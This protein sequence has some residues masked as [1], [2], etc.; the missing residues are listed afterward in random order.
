MKTEKISTLGNGMKVVTLPMPEKQKAA[1]FVGVRVGSINENDKNNGV[2]HF[3]EHMLFRSNK[4]RNSDQIKRDLEWKG[5]STNAFTSN[6]STAFFVKSPPHT[7]KDAV[8]IGFEAYTNLD[9]V[10]KE[11]D[12]EREVIL[13]EIKRSRENHDQH[14]LSNLLSP[15]FFKGTDLERT[16]LGPEEVISNISRDAMAGFKKKF[17]VPQNTVISVVGNFDENQVLDQLGQTFG[18]LPAQEFDQEPANTEVDVKPKEPYY[19]ERE[20]IKQLYMAQA[21]KV[22]DEFAT[23]EYYAMRLL[24][25]AIGSGLSSRMFRELR[26]KRGV[27]YVTFSMYWGYPQGIIVFY[28]GGMKPEQLDEVRETLEEITS[29]IAVNSLPEEEAEG[30]RNKYVSQLQDSLEFVEWI[31]MSLFQKTMF[32]LPISILDAIDGANSVSGDS[33]RKVAD[34]HLTKPRIEVGLRPA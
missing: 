16:V 14:V 23:D 7:L 29:D 9:Y 15:Y 5:I 25:N 21:V 34:I 17:Y 8:Q 3:T 20:N 32:D 31:A 18:K 27:G 13:G 26:D 6:N 12:T 22:P 4:Y 24:N 19:E 10:D 11:L 33:L 28:V 1:L 30:V 2:S